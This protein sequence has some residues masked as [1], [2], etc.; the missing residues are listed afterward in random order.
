MYKHHKLYSIHLH[1]NEVATEITE[2]DI[3]KPEQIKPKLSLDKI[4]ENVCFFLSF[5]QTDTLKRNII[6][7][8]E[9]T[10]WVVTYRWVTETKKQD[11]KMEV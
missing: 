1:C 8:T 7:C 5:W 2:T 9:F 6:L 11:R 10:N 3:S 4:N